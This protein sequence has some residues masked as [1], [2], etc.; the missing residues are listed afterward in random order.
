MKNV[1]CRLLMLALALSVY[2]ACTQDSYEKG[3]GKYSLLRGDF[4]E[5]HI[6]SDKQAVAMT[7]D[8][9]DYFVLKEPKSASW[10]AK[11]D[12]TYRGM[13]YYNKVNGNDGKSQAEVISLGRV[14]CP[15][16]RSLASF[17]KEVHTD[18]VKFESIWLS[19]TG[20]YLNLSLQLKTGYTEDT[21]AVQQLAFL[22]DTIV[23][24]ADKSRTLHC[25]LYHNQNNVPE[26]YSTQAYVSFPTDSLPADSICI[27]INTYEGL[28]VKRL[29]LRR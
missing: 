25:F 15:A 23:V 10:F 11:A 14:P 8:D 21:T 9:G 2:Y 17:E 7:T 29:S 22:S 28:V 4:V 24:N 16:V 5:L 12:T 18:P 1:V 26:Y 13:L 19:K 27:A 20:K 6:N 3:E